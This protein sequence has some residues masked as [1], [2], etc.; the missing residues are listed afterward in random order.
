LGSKILN[1]KLADNVANRLGKK[2]V[3]SSTISVPVGDV[4]AVVGIVAIT[5]SLEELECGKEIE[6]SKE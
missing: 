6:E 2:R 3:R 4:L 1:L 5:K